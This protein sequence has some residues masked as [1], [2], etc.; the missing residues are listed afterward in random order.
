MKD[1]GNMWESNPPVATPLVPL[2]GPDYIMTTGI[3]TIETTQ[4]LI[5]GGVHTPGSFFPSCNLRLKS[6][7]AQRAW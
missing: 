7:G 3:L 2:A 4:S 1:G 5:R 6:Q